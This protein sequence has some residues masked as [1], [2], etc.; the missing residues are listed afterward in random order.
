MWEQIDLEKPSQS[1]YELCSTDMILFEQ[2]K[3]A[4]CKLKLELGRL[5]KNQLSAK[6]NHKP[7][8]DLSLH[9]AIGLLYPYSCDLPYKSDVLA[10]CRA[11]TFGV[12]GLYTTSKWYDVGLRCLYST[13]PVELMD[14]TK[15]LLFSA[16]FYLSASLELSRYAI[17]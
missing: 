8:F 9:V 2:E 11:V 7:S 14:A 13:M 1:F 16:V 3:S 15:L 5:R 12:A 6:Q 4:L 10:H 17:L